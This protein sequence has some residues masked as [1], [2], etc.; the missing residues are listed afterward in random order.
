[1]KGP[2]R[3]LDLIF[4]MI[5]SSPA[6]LSSYEA[7]GVESGLPKLCPVEKT[8]RIAAVLDGGHHHWNQRA[9]LIFDRKYDGANTAIQ[10]NSATAVL[11]LL[12]ANAQETDVQAVTV[13]HQSCSLHRLQD[14][15]WQLPGPPAS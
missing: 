15:K 5:R 2:G 7:Y 11:S 9:I 12:T 14:P 8:C 4:H 6:A 3:Q 10:Q 1:V 13:H